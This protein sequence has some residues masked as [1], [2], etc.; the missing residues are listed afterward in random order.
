MV[1]AS[2]LPMGCLVLTPWGWMERVSQRYIEDVAHGLGLPAPPSFEG[3]V[4]LAGPG[5]EGSLN[6]M[7]VYPATELTGFSPAPESGI[8]PSSGRN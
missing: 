5:P 2:E 4:Y 7:A 6:I 1:I 3:S 8:T